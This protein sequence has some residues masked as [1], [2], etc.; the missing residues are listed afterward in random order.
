MLPDKKIIAFDIDGTLTASKT[1]ITESMANLI[2]ELVKQ[3][4]VI[5]IA[6]GSFHQMETQFLPPFLNDD[7]MI[8]F[9]HNF[10]LLPTS[11]SQRYEYDENKKEW[12]LADKEPLPNGV[13]EKA[14]KLL[15]EVIDNPI[16]EIPPNPT[17]NI[18]EDRDTQITFTPNGQQAPVQ[19]KMRFDPDRK[20]REKIKAFL[21]PK[22]PEVSI[23]IN[24]TSSI[25]I[26]AKGFNKA[27]G[28]VRFLDKAGLKK[29]DVVFVGDGLFPGGNDY[30]V[31]EAGFETIAV[32]GPEETE[33]IIKNWLS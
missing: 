8:P 12:I 21:E 19:L 9:I 27:V 18:I 31:Y 29:S 10:T 13:K 25:D 2:K 15:Q 26:L 23:L 32:K 17:G 33:V 20:K 24:G 7:S 14:I 1:L 3:K 4:I 5:A 16:Y 30:S 11:G 6:G 22:L 28:L